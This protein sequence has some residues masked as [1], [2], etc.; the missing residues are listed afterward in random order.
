MVDDVNNDT[1]TAEDAPADQ[2]AAA[3]HPQ[4]GMGAEESS[5]PQHDSEDAA[6]TFAQLTLKRS[7]AET[8]IVFPINPPAVVGRFD[9]ALGPIDVDL[10]PLPEGSYV[11][12]KHAK[13]VHEDGVWKVCDM[14]SSNGTFIL[15][16][17]FERV[18]EA[19]IKDGDEI[20]FG[21]ARFVFHLSS[22]QPAEPPAEAEPVPEPQA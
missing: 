15:R 6:C 20:A 16:S 13:V 14:G 18:E 10:G 7:G 22:A 17:D 2:A 5:P 21:N 9:P 19:E 11:S 4:A 1:M 12:R 8:D 3:D